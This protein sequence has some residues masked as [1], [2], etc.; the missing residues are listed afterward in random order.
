M[1]TSAIRTHSDVRAEIIPFVRDGAFEQTLDNRREIQAQLA[2]VLRSPLFIQSDRLSR[3]LS[4]A[5]ESTLAGQADCLKEY[6]VGIEAYGRRPD[7]DPSQDSIVRTEARRLRAKLQKYYLGE[8]E[9]DPVVIEFRPG[10]YVPSFRVTRETSFIPTVT[11]PSSSMAALSR[12]A[13]S[14]LPFS[15]LTGDTFG[16]AC[17]KG[18]TD[19]FMHRLADIE[20]IRVFAM[21][22]TQT[23]AL[24]EPNGGMPMS[25]RITAEGIVRTEGNHIRVTSR[26]R[27]LDGL[28]VASWRF[29]AETEP[30]ALFGALEA[31]ACEIVSRIG[32]HKSVRMAS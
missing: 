20:G 16:E 21:P 5:V 7:F 6:T 12:F 17:A 32:R 30:N 29:D 11:Q 2:R 22:A 31:I 18:L 3:F 9:S 13:I 23:A 10:T 28:N 8:G 27:D 24:Q 1:S 4:F 19:E 25:S 14:V 15:H 26:L